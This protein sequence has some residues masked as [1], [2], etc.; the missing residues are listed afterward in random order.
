MGAWDTG[1]YD[2]DDAADWAAQL[3]VGGLGAVLE[4]LRAAL[5][6][7]ELEAPDGAR[8]LAAADVIARLQSGG[9]EQS[10]YAEEVTHWVA[11]NP[12]E[13]SAEFAQLAAAALARVRGDASELRQLW[14][15]NAD[16]FGAWLATIDE[17]EQRLAG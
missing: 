5:E 4:A 6:A 13:P 16:D 3:P 14:A 9:G 15:E 8:A 12:G 1:V 17:I 10:V 7:D 11:K 2:N